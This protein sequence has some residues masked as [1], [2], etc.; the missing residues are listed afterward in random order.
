MVVVFARAVLVV[1]FVALVRVVISIVATVIKTFLL[2]L[3][4][5]VVAV[6]LCCSCSHCH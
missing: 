1:I 6:Q 4:C 5:V 2:L 3:G